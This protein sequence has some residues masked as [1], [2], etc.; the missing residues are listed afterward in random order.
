MKQNRYINSEQS[1]ASFMVGF[2]REEMTYGE[3]NEWSDYLEKAL[4]T[5][6]HQ[7]VVFYGANYLDELD[8]K[9]GERFFNFGEI[10]IKLARNKSLEDLDYKVMSYIEVETLLAILDA[11]DAYKKENDELG[12]QT[13]GNILC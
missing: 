5:D 10:S 2:E 4:T 9:P 13:E 8:R 7:A 11:V 3:Y 1:I 12:K 6:T